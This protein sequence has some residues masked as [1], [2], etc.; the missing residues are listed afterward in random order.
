MQDRSI[1]IVIADDHTVVREGLI[2][3]INT[4]P[5]MSVIAQARSWSQAIAKIDSHRPEVAMLDLRM[6]EME[7]ADG[8][9]LIRRICPPV[10]IVL[11]SAFDFEEDIYRVIRAG[12]NGFLVKDCPRQEFQACLRA[13]L[14]GK[15]W[16]SPGSAAKLTARINA[17]QITPCQKEVLA[18]MAAGKTNKEVGSAMNI[19]EGTVKIH[20]NQ[21]LKKL[22]VGGRTAAVTRALQRGLF[23]LSK[24]SDVSRN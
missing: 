22:G 20:V 8:V 24:L 18:L 21:I 10:R 4:I 23:H 19:T 11:I 14:A 15:T 1:R 12:A 13:V 5:G 9:E 7:A 6:P 16:L 2:S 3:I 17:P